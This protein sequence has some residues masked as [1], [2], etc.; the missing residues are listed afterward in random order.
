MVLI[1]ILKLKLILRGKNK[2]FYSDKYSTQNF[3]VTYFENSNLTLEVLKAYSLMSNRGRSQ[4][5][6]NLN[7]LHISVALHKEEQFSKGIRLKSFQYEM[8]AISTESLIHET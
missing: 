3:E 1:E 2:K 8:R 7:F 5:F 4:N 6:Q